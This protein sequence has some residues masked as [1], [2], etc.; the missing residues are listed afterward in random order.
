VPD[1]GVWV[2]FADTLAA[3]GTIRNLPDA[4]P[5]STVELKANVTASAAPR[6]EKDGRLAAFFTCTQMILGR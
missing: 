1:G 5:F 6:I 3:W 2:A 4:A